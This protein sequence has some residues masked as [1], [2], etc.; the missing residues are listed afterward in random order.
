[1]FKNH[2]HRGEWFR[3]NSLVQRA[4]K[5]HGRYDLKNTV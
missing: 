5:L 4:I 3:Y 2:H 1:V